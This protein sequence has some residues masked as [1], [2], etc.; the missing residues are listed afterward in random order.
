MKQAC[1]Y[2]SRLASDS[3]DRPLSLW[4][5]IRLKL[6]LSMCGNCQNCDN[7]LKL[8]RQINELM[9]IND[10]GHSR[11]S[12]QQLKYLHQALDADKTA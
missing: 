9:R 8:M 2:A 4:E 6:H 1:H 3:L 11:L 12:E 7:N 10:Y 5:R